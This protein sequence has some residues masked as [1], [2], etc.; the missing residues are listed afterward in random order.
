M[1]INPFKN[2]LHQLE[3]ARKVIFSSD[4]KNVVLDEVMQALKS[5]QRGI[6]VSV[7]LKRDDS[8]LDF[9]NGYRV[10]YNNFLGA[11][12]GG[13]RFSP[14]ADMDEVRALAFWMTIK[15]ALAGLPWG[16]AKGGIEIDALKLSEKEL[17]SLS[18]NYI[19]LIADV[20]GPEKD[21]P[22]PDMNTNAK[23]MDWMVDEYLKINKN[24]SKP[25]SYLKAAFTG[26]SIANGG[27]EGRE[28]ATGKGGVIVLQNFLEKISLKF[29]L[30][31]AVQGFGNVGFNTAK[32]LHQTG[33]KVVAVSDIRG[34]IYFKEGLNPERVKECQLEKGT[35]A[36]C[37]CS[38]SVCQTT[39]GQ[40]INNQEILE[41]DVDIL[42]PAAIEN[43]ITQ[44]NASK[45]KAK[46]ILEMA[47]G[48]TAPEADPI[49]KEKN[50][51][52]I[53]D[54]LANSGGV[55]VSYFEWQQ[56]LANERWTKEQVF[57]KLTQYMNSAATQ[58]W[59]TAQ[60]FNTSLRIAA[61]IIA[62][63]RISEAYQKQSLE[64]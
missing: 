52:V 11:Y 64:K 23:I 59:Q 4:K 57:E 48:P 19:R 33:F 15:C 47:N 38:G 8:S 13:I 9:F 5:P 12:K 6:S 30:T 22:A 42:V 21:I 17:E 18:R 50:I 29:P 31:A 20:I 53:P 3:E 46:V 56:N 43:I 27:S 1:T 34:G 61:F 54:V 58:V 10:Q 14:Q 37:Y 44:E 7:P 24:S 40:V 60:D 36:G 16:G 39:G 32:I 63:K 49:L 25:E 28:E 35:L 45:I 55:T 26:K 51:L 62:L 41:M 2:A